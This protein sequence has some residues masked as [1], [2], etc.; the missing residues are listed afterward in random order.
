MIKIFKKTS[1]VHTCGWSPLIFWT[2]DD[3]LLDNT[4]TKLDNPAH[5][6]I[7]RCVVPV[8]YSVVCQALQLTRTVRVK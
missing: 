5:E 4:M 8:L 2:Q 1:D 7:N 3:S 6:T